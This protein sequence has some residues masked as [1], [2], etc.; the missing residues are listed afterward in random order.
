MKNKLKGVLPEMLFIHRRGH[1]FDPYV[2]GMEDDQ[3]NKRGKRSIF[4]LCTCVN[5][6]KLEK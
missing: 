5:L 3:F 4:T 1:T 6:I 2:G